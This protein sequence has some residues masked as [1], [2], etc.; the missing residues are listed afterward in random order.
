MNIPEQNKD[1]PTPDPIPHPIHR[2]RFLPSPKTPRSFLT[3][4]LEPTRPEYKC[5]R[6]PAQNWLPQA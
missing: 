1:T 3:G 5:Q 6:N 2:N 4:N